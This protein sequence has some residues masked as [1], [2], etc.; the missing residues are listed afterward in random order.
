MT[1]WAIRAKNFMFT[2]S[3]I[4]ETAS[5]SMKTETGQIIPRPIGTER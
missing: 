3:S 2:T 5:L 1:Y 4:P